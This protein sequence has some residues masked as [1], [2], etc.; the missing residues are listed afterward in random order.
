MLHAWVQ[1]FDVTGG[2]GN[3]LGSEQGLNS[4]SPVLREAVI[5]VGPQKT[6]IDQCQFLNRHLLVRIDTSWLL[7]PVVYQSQQW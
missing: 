6:A 3:I 2:R 5:C 1:R 7:V 4:I